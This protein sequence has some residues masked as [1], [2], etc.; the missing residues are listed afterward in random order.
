MKSRFN[1]ILIISLITLGLFSGGVFL[2]LK[3]DVIHFE[4]T[5]NFIR[6]M[7]YEKAKSFDKKV[8][9]L[10]DSQLQDWPF[11]RTLHKDM[12]KY[13]NERGYGFVNAAHHGF[14][15][16]EYL[17]EFSTVLEHYVPDI[18]LIFYYA[19]NDLGNVSYRTDDVP[20]KRSNQVIFEDDVVSEKNAEGGVKEEDFDWNKYIE[21]RV[22][23][24]L[25]EF[26]KNRLRDPNNPG[27]RHINPFLLDLAS[28][29]PNSLYD[30][31]AL[32]SIETNF[33][34]YRSLQFFE[35]IMEMADSISAKV[36][37]V[38]I[39]HNVQIDTSQYDFYRRLKFRISD[40]LLF[41]NSPQHILYEFCKWNNIE[42]LDL[43]PYY[44]THKPSAELYLPNDEHLSEA[45]QILAYEVS[46]N[47][48]FE[49]LLNENDSLKKE[50]KKNYYKKFEEF[51]V[52]N[53]IEKIR[54]DSVWFNDI[55]R[56]AVLE[57]RSEEEQLRLDAIF[58]LEHY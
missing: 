32:E 43:L 48:I 3:Y 8:L 34:W 2:L 39:P 41:S 20:M 49:K 19:G 6:K 57:N 55:Q 27:L 31:C 16:I 10:G 56:K 4:I 46:E 13:F 35:R 29:K 52:L 1:N 47:R 53:E 5:D 58:V 26:A 33:G 23:S 21:M 12:E 15:P 28:W 40:D 45:G 37:L 50:R 54:N 42:Y 44:K 36:G 22:D 11:D 17:N 30:N 24:E 38:V 14:G 7:K 18:L 9:V 51:L 25:I